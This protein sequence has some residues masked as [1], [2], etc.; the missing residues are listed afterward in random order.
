MFTLNDDLS[1]YAT[2][3]DIV[4]FTVGA[5]EDGEPYSFKAG[6]V[7]RI[8]VFGKKD[9]EKVVLEKDFPITEN[10]TEV[11]IYLS[12]EDTKFGDVISKPK[13]Y[14]Y[15]IELNPLTNPQ[16]I[17]G[18][19]ED[20]AKVFKLFP[21]GADIPAFEPTPEDIPFMDDELDLTSTRPVQNQAIARAVV[22]LRA[23][24]DETKESV[25]A[26]SDD[27]AK[28]AAAA[29]S[30]VAVERA[31]IDNLIAHGS[32]TK[33]SKNLDYL[34]TI[35]DETKA[36]IDGHISSDGVFAT[37]KVNWREANQIYGGTTVNM[38]IIPAECRPISTGLIHTE[39]GLRYSINYDTVNKY[40][41]F[42]IKAEDSVTVAPSGAGTVTFSYELGDHELI[43][44][45][46]GADGK[47]YASAGAAVREQ[48]QNI[49]DKNLF[50]HGS[51]MF[52]GATQGNCPYTDVNDFPCNSIIVNGYPIS[53]W[54]A[55]MPCPDFIGTFVTF[56]HSGVTSDGGVVQLAFKN[57]G[58]SMFSRIRWA[59]WGAWK[60]TPL[61]DVNVTNEK[62]IIPSGVHIMGSNPKYTSFNDLPLNTVVAITT[63]IADSPAEDAFG[64][65]L[66]LNFVSTQKSGCVQ[67]FYDRKDH[68]FYIRNC[69]GNNF[70]WDE[71]QKCLNP[72]DI[73][74]LKADVEALKLSSENV[75]PLVAS[76]LKIGCIGDSL[77]S[78]ESI[79]KKA[80]GS[81][82]YADIY[83][84][85]WGQFMAKHYGIEC[86]NFSVG[87]LSTRSYW[88]HSRGWA[89][90]QN[91]LCNG[92]IIGLGQNDRGKLGDEY[93]GT[94]AD[95]DLADCEKNADTY[96]G[97]YAKIIQK[98]KEVQ[99]KAKFFL[100]TDP[101]IAIDHAYN[102]AVV[103]IA[104]L[105]PD[106]Y[107]I[108]LTKYS[109]MYKTGG[110]FRANNRGGHYNSIAYNYM[111]KIIGE[112]ISKYMYTNPTEFAQVEFIGTEYEY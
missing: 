27:T 64:T 38:F 37:I 41:Y 2:R 19:D 96:Y 76:F 34:E 95:I 16:T 108:D 110:F 1:I 9:A 109:A 5:N 92:Y 68:S 39:D 88:T 71:W 47:N 53:S 90:A 46:V 43:D 104:N 55:N 107:L 25:T 58:T 56:S 29:E 18:Y 13:D 101:I 78:G 70:E 28:V 22:S 52:I 21:E 12:K 59:N 40:Y 17:I 65:C 24:F 83:E 100:L 66:T 63:P 20:G 49:T 94:L 102:N 75:P 112:E 6:D 97:N 33:V 86:V 79:Y 42:A 51:K 7:V 80:D 57:T 15:E 26:K 106:C 48:I 67:L 87:G 35:T 99:P 50:L 69:W 14:W 36:K 74:T 81:N 4:F 44:V 111:G 103:E 93:L 32:G 23:A 105:L 91:N 61:G 62:A 60:E 8:K 73:A 11:Q 3:G 10:T 30:A 72:S 82:G 85:S 77:A 54:M 84:H 89:S 31:R 45:R 98:I